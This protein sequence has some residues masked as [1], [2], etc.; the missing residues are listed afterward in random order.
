MQT[1][2]RQSKIGR[3]HRDFA[4]WAIDSLNCNTM[5]AGQSYLGDTAV[6]AFLLQQ[7]RVRGD[8]HLAAQRRDAR[9]KWYLAAEPARLAQTGSLRTGVGVA[10][11]SHIGLSVV[12]G[13]VS[14]DARESLVLVTHMGAI[15]SGSDFLVSVFLWRS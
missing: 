5:I 4:L 12:G 8:A 9:S 14:F 1:V 10:V 6:A 13:L 2:L 11:R 7:L 3:D 15:C